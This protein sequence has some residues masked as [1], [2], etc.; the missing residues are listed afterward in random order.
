MGWAFQR[1]YDHDGLEAEPGHYKLWAAMAGEQDAGVDGAKSH[2]EAFLDWLEAR[3]LLGSVSATKVSTDGQCILVVYLAVGVDYH[4]SSVRDIADV[5][6]RYCGGEPTI[7]VGWAHE[8]GSE[9]LAV[10]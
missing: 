6:R 1:L 4:A 10:F 7:K 3:N 8:V 5:I 2:V 9:V